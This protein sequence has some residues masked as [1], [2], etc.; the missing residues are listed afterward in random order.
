MD[1][2]LTG[3]V[4]IVTG[5]SRG[6]GRAIAM[7]LGSAGASIVLAARS[8]A[9]L[10]ATVGQLNAIDQKALAVE[11]DMTDPDAST[12]LV[13]SAMDK[14][15]RIDILVNCAASFNVGDL[16][17][18]S[19]QD[20]RDHLEL[21]LLGYARTMRS[22]LPLMRGQGYGRIV[23]V[24]GNAVRDPA[25]SAV[26]AGPINAAVTNLTASLAKSEASWGITVNAVHPGATRTNR[27][28]AKV[29]Q[30]AAQHGV[31]I[32]EAADSVV[33]DVPIGR[34]IEPEEIAAAVRFFVSPE[35]SAITGQSLA[36]DG[37][38]TLG[39]NY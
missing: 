3:Q 38:A 26:L 36:V 18:V 8:K 5:A 32:D 19:D 25:A 17:Q 13:E 9:D 2:G 20:W 34:A 24:A 35:A 4:G 7:E 23:N 28:T 31:T 1:S 22:V 11:L 12:H 33:I 6:I 16:E 37:G 15:G 30:Y 27:H 14:F 39:V 10:D 29:E 21:K